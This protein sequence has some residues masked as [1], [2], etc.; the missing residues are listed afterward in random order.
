MKYHA[1]FKNEVALF[2]QAAAVVGDS[3]IVTEDP[4]VLFNTAYPPLSE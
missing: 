2:N 4:R 3:N 1:V